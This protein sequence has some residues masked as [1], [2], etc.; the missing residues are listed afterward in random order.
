MS[1]NR[2]V[3][4]LAALLAVTFALAGCSLLPTG[5]SAAV[6]KPVTPTVG[7][8]WNASNA[9][10]GEW[11]NWKGTA[12][13]TCAS[14]H[15]L[16]TY[17]V[18]KISGVS[19][20][21]W[22][23]P[24]SSSSLSNDVQ[25][26]AEDACSTT[27]LLPKLKW[28]QQLV[29]GFFFVPSEAQWKAGA[30]WVRCDIGVLGYG[31]T[32]A[33]E[34]LAKLPTRISTLVASVS[35]DPK[36]YDFCVDSPVPVSETGPLDNAAARIADCRQNPQWALTGHGNLPEPAGAAFPT[37]PTANN[38]SAAICSKYAVND[39]EIWI[40]YLPTESDWKLTNSREVQCWIGQKA[41]GGSGG[42][43]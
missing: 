40:A 11:A 17:A 36:R 6:P 18:G 26:K 14:S 20:N 23:A 24:G 31:A 42:L 13:V 41:D 21:S 22:A 2:L 1:R 4:S 25:V 32:L 39:N 3:G 29:Q 5:L 43:A 28:N 35:S 30:R 33:N 38:E 15:V 9:E 37:E 7:Q 27:A 34:V 19:A 12:A 8:C 16:Y 10:A